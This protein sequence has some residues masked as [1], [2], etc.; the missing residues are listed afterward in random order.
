MKLDRKT[1]KRSPGELKIENKTC[2]RQNSESPLKKVSEVVGTFK[3]GQ[4]EGTAKVTY[5]DNTSLV[6]NFEHG[7]PVGMRRTWT[8]K[9]NLHD[10]FVWKGYL[11]SIAWT[12]SYDYLIG[13]NSSFIR[14]EAHSS[15]CVLVPL[16]KF[17]IIINTPSKK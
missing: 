8:S 4:L 1:M 11:K 14:D 5:A 9:N 6:S 15:L 17:Q 7:H 13:M 10:F 16:G 2:I 12:R 3:N